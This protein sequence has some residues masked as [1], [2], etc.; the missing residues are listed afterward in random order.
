MTKV[1]NEGRAVDVV[2]KDLRKAFDKVP[3]GRLIQK[4]K[5]HGI[6]SDLATWIQN[7]LAH[8]WQRVEVEGC[9]SG[10]RSV[11][12]GDRKGSVLGHPLFV[13][14]INDLDENVDGWV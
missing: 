2:Y 14:Y 5:I 10:R 13:I 7:W 8:K 3:Y 1:I 6:C 11:T 12:S 9:F 4:I